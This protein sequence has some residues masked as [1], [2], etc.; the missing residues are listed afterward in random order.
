MKLRS[1]VNTIDWL[2]LEKE[3]G[4]NRTFMDY[5]GM[6]YGNVV[7]GCDDGGVYLYHVS[8]E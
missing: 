4:V 2:P 5:Y 1:S 3:P 8:N 7:V 6:N